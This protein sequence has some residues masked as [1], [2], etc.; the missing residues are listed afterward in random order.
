MY[1]LSHFIDTY[2]NSILDFQ[3]T[4]LH[5]Y[6][7]SPTS[8]EPFRSAF[9]QPFCSDGGLELTAIGDHSGTLDGCCCLFGLV[10]CLDFEYFFV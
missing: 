8:L 2:T 7:N 3:T 10:E 1:C 4:M 9:C 6:S 5:N